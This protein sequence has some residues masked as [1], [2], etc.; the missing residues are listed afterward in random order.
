MF[1]FKL[2]PLWLFGIIIIVLVVSMLWYNN[3]SIEGFGDAP[4]SGVL[5]H[6]P[7]A[8][9]NV[10]DFGTGSDTRS[11]EHTSELQSRLHLVCRLLLD[12]KKNN[13]ESQ[14]EDCIVK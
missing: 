7:N 4:A 13:S 8:T 11:E 1:N 12:R 14:T 9:T 10:I 5:T 6:Y 2:T 3:A